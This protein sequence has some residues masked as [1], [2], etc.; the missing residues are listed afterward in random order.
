MIIQKKILWVFLFFIILFLSTAELLFAQPAAPT[1]LRAENSGGPISLTW[2]ASV[3][4]TSYTLYRS[5]LTITALTDEGVEVAGIST[6]TTFMD[7]NTE[8]LTT[9]HYV[10]TAWDADGESAGFSNEA[11]ATAFYVTQSVTLTATE[12]LIDYED[13]ATLIGVST[14]TIISWTVNSGYLAKSFEFDIIDNYTDSS[15]FKEARVTESSSGMT[16]DSYSWDGRWYNTLQYTKHNGSYTVKVTPTGFD[17]QPGA[18]AELTITVYVVHINDIIQTFT[19]YGAT[20]IA[21]SLPIHFSYQ[22]TQDAWTTITIYNTNGTEVTTDDTEIKKFTY[23]S[24]RNSEG[25]SR[26][27][28]EYQ[29]WDGTDSDNKLVPAGIYRFAIDAYF[30][31]GYTSPVDS[32]DIA[33]TRGWFFALDKRIVDIT[34]DAITET[35]SLAKIKYTLSEPANIKIKVCK[36]GTTFSTDP[37]TGEATPNPSTNL[38]KTFT[39]YQQSAGEQEVTWDGNDE[40]GTSMD[41]GLYLVVITATDVEGNIFFNTIGTDNLFRTTVTID[42]TTSQVATD[43]TPPTVSS[44]TPSNGSIITSPFTQVTATL[45]DEEDGS[46]LDLDNST[47]TL[48]DPTGATV[49][50]TTTND[51]VNTLTLTFDSQSTDGVYNI[52]VVPK[53]NVGNTGSDHTVSFTLNVTVSAEQA[54]FKDAV[55]VYPNP[56]KDGQATFAYTLSKASTVKLEIYTIM[57][58]LVYSSE[59]DDISG[60]RTWLWNCVNDDGDSIATGVY[61][62]KITA[63]EGSNTFE[64]TKKMI[65]VR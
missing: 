57:G 48:S 17:D 52:K 31:H 15:I 21:H 24:P 14:G 60:G 36:S 40:G 47:I 25:Q 51:G 63:K 42:R 55:Y 37:T 3:G 5:T 35:N 30:D 6:T 59:K 1:N 45:Q 2:T 12:T 41:N 49:S 4:A 13:S 62:Y 29:T 43:S 10:A 22:L 61:I 19:D 26:D 53:D 28:R 8:D 23:L 18:T 44:T 20:T 33:H 27:F 9:Y 32:M 7:I 46:G 54:T 65:V 50:G 16:G 39:F 38:V 56:V 58:E 64:T 34:T 11:M